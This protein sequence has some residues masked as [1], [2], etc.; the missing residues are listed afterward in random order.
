MCYQSLLPSG[1][2]KHELKFC[3]YWNENMAVLVMKRTFLLNV[4]L[5]CSI[6][7]YC[8]SKCVFETFIA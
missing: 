5:I 1:R 3:I 2:H 6:S 8:K 7:G 4:G